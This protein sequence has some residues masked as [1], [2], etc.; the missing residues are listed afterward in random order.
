MPNSGFSPIIMI[1]ISAIVT[2]MIIFPVKTVQGY[3][4]EPKW[5]KMLLESCVH[6]NYIYSYMRISNATECDGIVKQH[7]THNWN[8]V[9]E[10]NGEVILIFENNMTSKEKAFEEGIVENKQLTGQIESLF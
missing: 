5:D 1:V 7:D 9:T 6:V 8:F 2:M 10:R 4:E 3:P